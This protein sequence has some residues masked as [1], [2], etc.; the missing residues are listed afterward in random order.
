MT[1]RFTVFVNTILEFA[2]LVKLD[3]I[4]ILRYHPNL[5]LFITRF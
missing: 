2:K 1:K 3:D 4:P 5:S